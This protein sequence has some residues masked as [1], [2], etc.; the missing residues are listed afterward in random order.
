MSEYSKE[1]KALGYSLF[2][3]LS[4][5]PGLNHFHLKEMG[6]AEKLFL[7]CHYYPPCP[8]PELT[9]GTTKHTDSSFM[10]VL[11]QDHVGGLQV[12]HDNQWVDVPPSHGALVVNIGDLL[13]AS[14]SFLY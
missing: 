5:A 12:L 8:E 11:L 10:T 13:K 7:V 3:L 14:S 6:G 2:E 4:E 9:I 1:V